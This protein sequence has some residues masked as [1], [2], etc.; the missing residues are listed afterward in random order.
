M[1]NAAANSVVALKVAVDG[2][3]SDGSITSTGGAGE[4]GINAATGKP[5]A[6]DAL[7]SQGVVTVAGSVSIF[8]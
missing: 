5:A 6:P 2:K 8:L 1:T 4:N 3:L 7:F